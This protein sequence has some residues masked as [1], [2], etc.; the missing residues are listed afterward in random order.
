MIEV[1]DHFGA[2]VRAEISGTTQMAVGIKAGGSS[3][4][5]RCT[6]GRGSY[7]HGSCGGDTSQVLCFQCHELGHYASNC[8]ADLATIQ[9]QLAQEQEDTQS[10]YKNVAEDTSGVHLVQTTNSVD[11]CSDTS[12]IS[13]SFL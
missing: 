13:Y 10:Q 8:N 5:G 12:N 9:V 3:Q 7:G 1:P 6:G 2:N 11:P 4:G